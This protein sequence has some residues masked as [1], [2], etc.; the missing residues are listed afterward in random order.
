MA[1]EFAGAPAIADGLI[2][3]ALLGEWLGAQFWPRLY[4]QA[5]QKSAPGWSIPT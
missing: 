3:S 5:K 2:R 4:A 1:S